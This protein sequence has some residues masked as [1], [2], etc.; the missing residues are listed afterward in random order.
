MNLR[1]FILQEHSQR[2]C[3]SIADY[4][5]NNPQRFSE[6]V[7]IFLTGPYRI[8]QRAS[9]PISVCVERNPGLIKPHLRKMV[10]HLYQ[11]KLHDAVKRNIVR[12]LQFIDIPR[13]LQGKVADVCFRLLQTRKEPVAVRVF[14]MTVL[15]HLAREIPELKNELIPYIEDELPLGSAGFISRGKKIVKELKG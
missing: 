8:T 2:Q 12:L 1:K 9:W 14:S 10:Q 7:G 5:G 13:S 11:P 4:V 15:A 3:L 6:L